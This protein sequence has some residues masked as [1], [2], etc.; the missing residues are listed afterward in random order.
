MSLI[1]SRQCEYALQA[2]LYL[3]LRPRGEMTSIRRMAGHLKIPYHFLGKIMQSLCKTGLLVSVKGPAGG[4]A[5]ARPAGEITLLQI[6]RAV[7]GDGFA[8][9]CVLGL[10]RCSGR[11]HCAVHA[12]WR[13]VRARIVEMLDT[14]SIGELARETRKQ[15]SRIVEA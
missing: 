13:G 5:L 11:K 12:T 10:P 1:F 4:F 14:K 2:V 15:E 7:D 9:K 3:S 6:V 8:K